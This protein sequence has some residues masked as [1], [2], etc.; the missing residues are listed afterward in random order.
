MSYCDFV[1]SVC[2]AFYSFWRK[3]NFSFQS[4]HFCIYPKISGNYTP[5]LNNMLTTTRLQVR[6]RAPIGP[7]YR[8]S[9]PEKLCSSYSVNHKFQSL[10]TL[11]VTRIYVRGF[12]FTMTY[13]IIFSTIILKL[14]T[15]TALTSV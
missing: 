15:T 10:E 9:A 3:L 4:S 11:F 7:T 13:E 6:A 5:K 12:L 1:V 14:Q 2:C 8:R